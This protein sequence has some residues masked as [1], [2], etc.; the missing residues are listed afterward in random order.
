MN[1]S[2]LFKIFAYGAFV[3]ALV[4]ALMSFYWAAGGMIGLG[5]LGEGMEALA[6]ARDAELLAITWITGGLKLLAG[7]C[8]L[9]LAQNWF[10]FLPRR[11]FHLG[12][13]AAGILFLLYAL[14]NFV[15]H[16]RMAAGISPIP[17]LLG[18]MTAVHWH[19]LLWDP[20]WLAGGLL[21]SGSAW[22]Y[23]RHQRG[24]IG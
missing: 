20:F 1:D 2:R 19:L 12:T 13:W 23:R 9:A 15:Q 16:G 6:R 3:W 11:L 7:F 22:L 5:T 18:S 8:V 21:F 24:A 17:D 4:F 14:A 10:T